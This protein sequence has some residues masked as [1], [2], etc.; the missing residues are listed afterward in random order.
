MIADTRTAAEI[1]AMTNPDVTLNRRHN[2][3][4]IA[5]RLVEAD[6]QFDAYIRMLGQLRNADPKAPNA[7]RLLEDMKWADAEIKA[8]RIRMRDQFKQVALG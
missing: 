5:M 8:Y 2:C 6:R 1:E 4:D 3:M 7:D